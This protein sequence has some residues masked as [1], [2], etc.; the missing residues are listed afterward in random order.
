MSQDILKFEQ[1]VK[2]PVSRVYQAFTN[3]TYL[4]EW[5]CDVSTVNPK[6]GGR[7]YMAWNNGYYSCGE[8]TA[9][10]E[11][12]SIAFTW[13]GRGEPGQTEVKIDLTNLNGSTL[14]T[15]LHGGIGTGEAW[16]NTRQEI[17]DGWQTSLENLASVLETGEDLRFILRPMLG[18]TLN[19]FN[20]E[21]ANQLEIPVKRGIRVDDTVDG[22]G[23]QKAG[24]Q[25]DDVIVAIAGKKADDFASL[26]YALN[27]LKAG[28][29]VEV[30]FYRGPELIKVMMELSRRPLP[31]VPE[32]TSELAKAVEVRY[33]EMQKQLETFLDGVTEEEASY[34]ISPEEWN[35]KEVL[36]HLLQ[37]ERF[38]HFYIAE[39]VS[40][41]ER[42]ADDYAGNLQAA[43]DATVTVFPTLEKIYA[44]LKRIRQE[45]VVLFNK[46]PASFAEQKG[47]FWRLA[48]GALEQPYYHDNAHI[49]Q[50]KNSIEA[51]RASS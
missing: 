12:Q 5:L 10:E 8:Y 18:I 51:A 23:A 3:A 36:A 28:E 11:D 22:M 33:R 48:Y 41:Q 1:T 21:I 34:K 43:I 38:Y 30:E 13:H 2:T 44:E 15:L 35:V 31:D 42:W 40:G 14:V 26:S 46:L 4:R 27:G 6:P 16:E 50:M 24:L 9:L 39:L 47:S 29:I 25:S 19:D 17:Q 45:T 7:I 32:T 20:A 49:E 37:G